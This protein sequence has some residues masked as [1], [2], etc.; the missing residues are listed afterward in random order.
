MKKILLMTLSA[1]MGMTVVDAQTWPANPHNLAAADFNFVSWPATS[2]ANTY[3]AAMRF[4]FLGNT[5]DPLSTDTIAEDYTAVYNLSSGTRMNGTGADGFSFINTGSSGQSANGYKL[6]SAVLAINTTGRA[7]I[8]V[9]W[10]GKTIVPNNRTFLVRLFYRVGNTGS[11]S[12]VM[13]GTN[14]VEYVRNNTANH[15][16]NISAVTLPATVNNQSLVQLEWKYF[17]ADTNTVSGARPQLAVTNIHVSSIA[18]TAVSRIHTNVTQR[19]F[20]SRVGAASSVD[21][22]LVSGGSIPAAIAVQTAAPFAVSESYAGSYGATISIPSVADTVTPRYIYVKYTPVTAGTDNGTISLTSGLAA[23]N[24]SLTGIAYAS[25][26]PVPVALKTTAYTFTAWD[27]AAAAATYPAHTVFQYTTVANP[28]PT[29]LPLAGDWHC[30]YNLTSRPRFNGL[31]ED[32]ISFINTGSAQYDDC[33]SGSNNRNVYAGGIVAAL[34][35]RDVDSVVLNYTLQLLT[36]GDGAV[37]REYEVRLQYRTGTDQDFKDFAAPKVFASE[38]K[39]ALD[40]VTVSFSFDAALLNL[41]NM[42]LRWLYSELDVAGAGGSRPAFRL[43]NIQAKGYNR[44][45]SVAE[46]STRGIAYYPNPVR[47]GQSVVFDMP[48]SGKLYDL[49]GRVL[50]AFSDATTLSTE[51][52]NAGMYIIRTTDGSTA[53]LV[54]E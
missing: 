54:V 15:T 53:R 6:G 19:D 4:Y 23:H 50:K 18:L 11:W 45:V 14:Y 33:V 32:G 35:T 34:D 26:D 7:G 37:A 31:K 21:S 36:R 43:D 25:S 44:P 49:T 39:N 47:A 17:M 8:Q 22:V 5:G 2:A 40:S 16:Q 27:S 13:D 41:S 29:H 52:L 51:G 42:Q 3:P 10:T 46:W 12:P 24:V 48:V 1:V 28:K 9:S 38:N 30:G 20:H